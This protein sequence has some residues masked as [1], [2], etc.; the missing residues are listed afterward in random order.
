MARQNACSPI[1]QRAM[2]RSSWFLPAPPVADVLFHS[3]RWG[4]DPAGNPARERRLESQPPGPP[5]RGGAATTAAG[6]SCWWWPCESPLIHSFLAAPP[7]SA[8]SF[9]RCAGCCW[10]VPALRESAAALEGAGCG[11]C[12][13]A[14]FAHLAG[15]LALG[16][17]PRSGARPNN[18]FPAGLLSFHYWSGM[19]LMGLVAVFDA[20]GPEISSPRFAL[21]AGLHGAPTCWMAVLLRLPAINRQPRICGLP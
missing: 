9:P 1:G 20:A 3:R 21:P 15:L 16:A 4:P 14:R 8:V 19:L 5:A 18:P 10:S 13:P 17:S 11:A 6:G 2:T 7:R 12:G